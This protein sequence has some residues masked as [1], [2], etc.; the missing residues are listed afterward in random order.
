M[1]AAVIITTVGVA[2]ILL[3]IKGFTP[4]GIAFSATKN[5]KGQ[6]GRIVGIICIVAGSPIAIVGFWL[7]VKVAQ[8]PQRR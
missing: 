5:L 7:I 3:G 6:T 8:M 1:V 4:E 2:L